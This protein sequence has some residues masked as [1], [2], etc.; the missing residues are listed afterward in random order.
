MC[1]CLVFMY[2]VLIGFA[3]YPIFYNQLLFRGKSPS[4]IRKDNI[5]YICMERKGRIFY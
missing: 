3:A 1:V 2:V 5:L 4:L